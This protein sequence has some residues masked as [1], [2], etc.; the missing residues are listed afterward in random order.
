MILDSLK[1]KTPPFYL[2]SGIFSK[3]Y[4]I[5]NLNRG[6]IAVGGAGSGKTY[7]YINPLLSYCVKYKGCI[8]FDPKGELTPL[9]NGIA[10]QNN[11]PIINFSLDNNFDTINVLSLCDDKSDIIEFSSY[12]L[13][14]I[15]GIPKNDAAKYFFNAAKSILTGTIIFL[16]KKHPELCSIPHII[17]LFLTADPE[18]INELPRG[19]AIEVSKQC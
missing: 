19:R 11:K 2:K 6:A 3:H 17:A 18:Q 10:K 15:V 7:S 4:R 16:R 5:N 12:F 14:G 1:S 8:T 13:S 9:I